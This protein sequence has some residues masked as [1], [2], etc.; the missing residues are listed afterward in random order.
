MKAIDIAKK[1]IENSG[2][3]A[4]PMETLEEL[5]SLI[6]FY[7]GIDTFN[8]Q[9]MNEI[10]RLRKALKDI[11]EIDHRGNGHPSGNIARAALKEKK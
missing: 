6:E 1:T 10:N 8:E 11:A 4:I 9:L 3:F 7:Q 5:V 2:G